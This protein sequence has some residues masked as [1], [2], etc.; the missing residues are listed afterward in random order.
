LSNPDLKRLLLEDHAALEAVIAG[1][2]ET[3]ESGIAAPDLGEAWTLLEWSLRDHLDAEER[4]I[5]PFVDPAL[6]DEVEALRGEHDQIRRLLSQLGVAVELSA[7]RKT[8]VAQ[9]VSFLR[10][11]ATREERSIYHDASAIGGAQRGLDS[12]FQRRSTLLA[13]A[14]PKPP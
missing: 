9:F 1:L 12:M 2:A 11:H 6:A 5:F 14:R 4:L 8:S 7:L 10:A 3:F 13:K